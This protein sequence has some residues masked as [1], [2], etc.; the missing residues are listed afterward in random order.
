MGVGISGWRLARAVSALGQLGVVS[1]TG[2]DTLF[3]RRLQDGDADGSLRRAMADFPIPEVCARVLERYF[4]PGG[5]P[6]GRPYRALSKFQLGVDRL[7][8]QIAV[9]A[10]YVEVRLAKEGHA[11]E[12]GINLLTKIQ[13]PNLAL[14]YGAMLAGVDI[15]LMGAGIPREIPKALDRLAEGRPA[16]MR[17]DVEGA[18]AGSAEQVM[19][20]P[21]E[22]AGG[23]PTPLRRPRFL[24]IVSSSS[25]A[26]L[27][28]RKADG[29]V[30][31]FVVE[32]AS[33][34]GHNA[35]P[36]GPADRNP[37]GEPVYGPRDEADL[38]RIRELGL[39][40]W[41]AGGAASPERLAAARA[42]GAA[43]VQVGTLFAFCRESGLA[44]ELRRRG[45]DAVRN[46][47]PDVFTDPAASPTGFPFK[48]LRLDGTLAD[49]DLLA[50]R[51]RVCDLGYLATTYRRPD[52]SI[53]YR[54]AAEPVESFVAKGGERAATAGRVCL[55]NALLATAGHPQTR[56]GG[57]VE[58]P[59]VTSGSEL[60]ALRSLAAR[61]GDYSAADVIDFLL[62]P[63]RAAVPSAAGAT[64]AA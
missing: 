5:R 6:P 11:G 25:L 21:R 10:S 56:P 15:V 54:C 14:L 59:I 30:D 20:D 32:A 1:G 22:L 38:E 44:P 64:G 48:V 2:L 24:P 45:L 39:P 47:S 40:F 35:P 37:R 63:R 43:G 36:R 3:V 28:A 26:T 19:I 29:R 9:L 58:P 7:R 12:V 46:G 62:A 57:A 61:E 31:G 13:P 51:R 50:E 41:L 17:L 18:A 4:R 49:P 34:G 55:C 16:A 60:A 8:Q 33:A 23:N 53:G 42:R 27:L 52:G